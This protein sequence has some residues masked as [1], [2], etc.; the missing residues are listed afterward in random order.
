MALP[1]PRPQAELLLR[2][3]P[4]LSLRFDHGYEGY[5]RDRDGH[6]QHRAANKNRGIVEGRTA[7]LRAF[8]QQF[9]DPQSYGDFLARREAALAGA[10]RTRATSSSPLLVGLGRW[11]PTGIGFTLDRFTGCPYIP[12]SSVKGVLRAAARLVA[13]GEI[14]TKE[15]P[16]WIEHA[17]RIFGRGPAPA[18]G[19]EHSDALENEDEA[20]NVCFY[21]AY[22]SSWPKI[23]LDVL[24]PH[25]GDYYQSGDAVTHPP[26][27]WNDPKPVHFLRVAANQEI[28]FWFSGRKSTVLPEIDAQ[29]LTALLRLALDWVGLGAK[30]SSGYGWFEPDA[31]K[32]TPPASKEREVTRVVWSPATLVHKPNTG[33][34]YVEFGNK[35]LYIKPAE[36]GVIPKEMLDRL[37]SGKKK[38]PITA[39]V[40]VEVEVG[41]TPR[42]VSVQ[43]I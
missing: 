25:Q 35:H 5:E 14:E 10:C 20:G 32:S 1:L 19:R 11:N 36:L 8:V 6:W 7:F 37:R 22:P 34:V 13:A 23:E 42:V 29:H 39:T 41:A 15:V 38:K 9:N 21:D 28:T 2:S 30:T 40:V 27:D 43:P 33:E 4:N 31:E 3:A 12:G 17:P 16:F 26:A 24:T 18:E